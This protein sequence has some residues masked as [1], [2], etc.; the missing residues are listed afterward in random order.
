MRAILVDDERLALAQLKKILERD[1]GGVQVI[2]MYSD[3]AD[4]VAIAEELAP[5]V[6]FLDIH[7]PGMN[8]VK[9]GELLQERVPIAEIVFVTGYDQYAVHA[10][11][12]YALDYIMKPVQPDR[13]S[14]TMQRLRRKI[15]DRANRD[16][17]REREAEPP[18]ICCFNQIRVQQ[19]GE[20]PRTI[21][22]RT[23]KA[24][25]LFAYL[26][27]HRDRIIE[28]DTL[29][30]LLWPD[31]EVSKAAQ[32]LYTT[33]YHI[34]QTLRSCGLEMVTIT[35][36]NLETGYR[37][38]TGTARIDSDEWEK[39]VHSLGALDIRHIEQYEK[40]L[41]LY[42]GDYFGDF[43][44]LWAEHERERLRRMWLNHARSV[45]EFYME[46]QMLQAAIRINRLIQQMFPYEEESYFALM[47]LYDDSGDI[48]GVEEQYWLLTSRVEKEMESAVSESISEW[49][50]A[51][52]RRDFKAPP[53]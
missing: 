33:V 50:D 52:K 4:V 49:F 3:P 51:W 34:R 1:V 7:M 17:E 14:K 40:V 16:E 11:E 42:K 23:S 2:G 9:L 53:F 8:G 37:L 28:R 5:D 38:T 10:F 25:E 46:Q 18:L 44:F 13:L 39:Q 15:G 24:Q 48:A 27:H 21:K 20:E 43:E 47:L 26:L 41:E 36:G 32:Q 12:L 22:W 6:V 45:S 35:S 29:I 31:F 19:S 30:E